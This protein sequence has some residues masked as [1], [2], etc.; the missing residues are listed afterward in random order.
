MAEWYYTQDNQQL[1]PIS[2]DELR[3]KAS[4]GL[5]Q[6]SDMIW[7]EG[8]VDWLKAGKKD[9]LFASRSEGGGDEAIEPLRRR[10]RERDDD[11]NDR[12]RRPRKRRRAEGMPLGAKVAIIG[13]SIAVGLLILV[14]VIVLLVGGRGTP[15]FQAFLMP[16]QEQNQMFT[17]QQ[18]QNVKITVQ[19]QATVQTDVDLFVLRANGGII[20]S[21]TRVSRDCYVS[22]IAPA[23]EM[24]RVRVVN[25]ANGRGGPATCSVYVR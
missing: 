18:G 25:L 1:G 9:G 21:D 14:V 19:S 8:M 12:D 7:K 6:S 17:F 10:S 15:T 11:D 3:Q 16:G 5:L 23:T 24:Y 4:S 13:G 22:F 2:W 20:A